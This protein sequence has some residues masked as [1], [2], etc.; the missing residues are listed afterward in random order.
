MRPTGLASDWASAAPTFRP[1]ARC[2]AGSSGRRG[3]AS[4]P[5]VSGIGV[6]TLVMPPLATFFIDA[7]GWREAYLLLGGF[8]AVVGG[9]MALLIENDPR[10]CRMGP[11]G[12]PMQS[13]SPA[14]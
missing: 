6:G 5:A 1:W 8:A 11:D 12:D 2:S 9:G 10:D 14:R 13:G 3:F 4:G 7:V